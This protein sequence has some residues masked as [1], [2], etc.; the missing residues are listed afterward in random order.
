[1]SPAPMKFCPQCAAPLGRKIPPG[2]HLQ[3]LVCDLCETILYEN[4]KI[5]AGCIVEWEDSVLLCRR[6]IDPRMGFWTFPAGF[7]ELGEGTEEAACRETLEEAQAI[8]QACQL[9]A[10]VSMPHIGQVYMV[11]RGQ[12]AAPDY[13]PGP[14]S[15]EVDLFVHDRI[16]WDSLAFPV[17]RDVLARYVS[18]ART[19]VFPLYVASLGPSK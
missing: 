7:M 17:I 13:R 1:M 3:R 15:L 9:Y 10:V 14:E 8:V 19:G 2:D 12:L 18:D 4:P 16:P 5:V 6:A 11:F